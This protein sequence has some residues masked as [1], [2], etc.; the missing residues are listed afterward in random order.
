MSMNTKSRETR[1][2]GGGQGRLTERVRRISTQ[3]WEPFGNGVTTNSQPKYTGMQVTASESH[4]WPPSKG[5]SGDVGGPF[6]TTEQVGSKPHSQFTFEEIGPNGGSTFDLRHVK[7]SMPLSCPI[8]F[9]APG[10][11]K[12]PTAASSSDNDLNALGATAISRCKPTSSGVELS[13]ALGETFKDGLPHLVGS[14]TWREKTLAARNAGSE[15]LNVEFG[16]LP[17]VSDVLD[18]GRTV[19]DS[20][21]ILGQYDRDKGQLIRRQYTFPEERT[22]QSEILSLS[23]NPDGN[24]PDSGFGPSSSGG[25]WVKKT[26]TVINRWF[27]GAFIYGVP[28]GLYNRGPFGEWAA[29][30]DRLFG[31]SL[32]PDT[33]WNL[34]PWSWA[35]D[36]FANTG[37][38]LS[39]ISDYASQGLVMQYGYLMEKKTVR[40]TYSLTGAIVHGRQVSVPDAS[41][42]VT[43]KR[44]IR[45]NPFGFGITWDGLS[46]AQIAILSA[47]GISRS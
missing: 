26:S 13:V 34:S 30:A 21:S 20:D 9:A 25:I 31:I 8:E 41:L 33:L 10:K 5:A 6:S 22:E 47:L 7:W 29:K 19:I 46:A 14:Q 1:A 16:W 27:S 4:N 2:F 42:V 32:T 24:S 17:L 12:W 44:R 39:N 3:K 23:K 37:D 35:A 36:W 40:A 18:F 45:A 15:Y 38:V 28:N 43:T 11:P